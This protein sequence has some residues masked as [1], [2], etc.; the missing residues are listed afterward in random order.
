M[1]THKCQKSTLTHF[2][3]NSYVKIASGT[4]VKTATVYF[5]RVVKVSPQFVPGHV[6]YAR[7]LFLMGHD[8]AA[9]DQ[10]RLAEKLAPNVPV[11][12]LALAAVLK[13]LGHPHQAAAE[14]RLAASHTTMKK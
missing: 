4:S 2:H 1:A 3:T 6:S 12:H 13:K 8:H 10:L 5:R 11:I 14:K 7:C 9:L